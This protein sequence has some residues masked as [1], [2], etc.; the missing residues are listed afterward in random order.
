MRILP[1]YHALAVIAKANLWVYDYVHPIHKTATEEVIYN[2]LV[3]PM[4]THDMGIVDGKTGLVV[5]GEELDG[6]YNQ[7]ILTPNNVWHL[8]RL[9]SKWRESQTQDKKVQRCSKCSEVG[10][11]SRTCCNPRAHFDASYK[12]DVVHIEDL[13]DGS[14]AAGVGW[15]WRYGS[16]HMLYI[17]FISCYW[18]VVIADCGGVHKSGTSYSGIRRM[19]RISVL[20]SWSYAL[21]LMIA[22]RL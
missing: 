14:Y 20:P 21:G 8:G 3:H 4:E 1:C 19:A 12:G 17:I 13:F 5:G 11:T 16:A 6:D 2:Q 22:V 18:Q 7:C 9:P 10:H 15:V